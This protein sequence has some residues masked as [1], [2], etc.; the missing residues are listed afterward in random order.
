MNP[1]QPA[2]GV[3]RVRDPEEVVERGATRP[4][5]PPSDPV[6]RFLPSS[7][8]TDPRPR[9]SSRAPLSYQDIAHRTRNRLATSLRVAGE[10]PSPLLCMWVLFS[11]SP[12]RHPTHG[13]RETA[14]SDCSC[15]RRFLRSSR[16]RT[17]SAR[18][19]RGRLCCRIGVAG[20]GS[21]ARSAERLHFFSSL[22]ASSS[23][24]L[25]LHKPLR[26]HHRA[27]ARGAAR[28]HAAGGYYRDRDRGSDRDRDRPIA[29]RAATTGGVVAAP[30]DAAQLRETEVAAGWRPRRDGVVTPRCVLLWR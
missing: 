20:A 29:R 1:P 30:R 26:R 18:Q 7:P 15:E 8:I 27:R 4:I 16:C 14:T 6:P 10:L 17:C 9:R 13:P 24:S 11:G 22:A 5:C 3:P 19:V 28:R 2:R 23:T 25:Q 12:G 21:H